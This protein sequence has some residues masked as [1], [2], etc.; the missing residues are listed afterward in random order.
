M[1]SSPYSTRTARRTARA[2]PPNARRSRTSGVATLAD[3]A[4]RVGHHYLRF[5]HRRRSR[6]GLVT[7]TRATSGCGCEV[8]VVVDDRLGTTGRRA[9]EPPAL[10]IGGAALRD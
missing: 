1:A 4:V 2:T 3:M 8:R 9:V 5:T 7:D 10:R 6:L